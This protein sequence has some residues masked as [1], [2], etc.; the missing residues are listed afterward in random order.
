LAQK[1]PARAI[2]GQVTD[3]LPGQNRTRGGSS[4]SAAN[5][6]QAKPAGPS[7]STVV[8]MVTPVQK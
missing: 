6:W 5:D 7:S 4:D 3:D 1:C 2:R 8:M